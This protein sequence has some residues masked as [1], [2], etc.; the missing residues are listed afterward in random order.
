MIEV[1][2]PKPNQ[3]LIGVLEE[4]LQRAREGEISGIALFEVHPGGLHYHTTGVPNRWE[5]MGYLVHML[6]KLALDET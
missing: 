2:K 5:A 6:H 4:A 3:D 1:V